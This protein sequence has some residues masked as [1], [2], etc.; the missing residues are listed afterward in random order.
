MK[1][2]VFIFLLD[3]EEESSWELNRPFTGLSSS[4]V[5]NYRI[6]PGGQVQPP[7]LEG[8]SQNFE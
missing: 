1:E 3:P 8:K 6:P 5:A 7:E 4:L 2:A